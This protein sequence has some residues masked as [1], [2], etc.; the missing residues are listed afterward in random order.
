M[1]FSD[2]LPDAVISDP[3]EAELRVAVQTGGISFVAD[4]PVDVGG[5]E[6]GPSPYDLLCAALGAC[7]AMTLKLYARRKGFPLEHVHVEVSHAKEGQADVFSRVIRL[8]GALDEAMRARLLEIAEHCP[9]HR[10]L[11]NGSRI[12]TAP[13]VA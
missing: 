9:V 10:T 12:N 7:S 11:T 8:E 3:G 2:P 4:E 6:S 1:A 13:T 5:L